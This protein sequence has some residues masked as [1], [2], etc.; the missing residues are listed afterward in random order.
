MFEMCINWKNPTG[1]LLD[2]VGGG[3]Q[4]LIFLASE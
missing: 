1:Q 4:K 3:E 2:S